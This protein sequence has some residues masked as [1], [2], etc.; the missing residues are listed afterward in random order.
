MRDR[1]TNTRHADRSGQPA[2]R[3]TRR[4]TDD[5]P[6]RDLY[7]EVTD[8]IAA[9]LEQGRIPWVQP[10]GKTHGVP[11]LGLPENGSTGATYSGINILLLWG[12]A[13]MGG[14]TTQRWVTYRQALALGGAS[15]SRSHIAVET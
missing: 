4:R 13:F 15:G 12:A 8:K 11:P 10:W 6:R 3:R 2:L 9:E 14:R 7:A 1:T 5:A